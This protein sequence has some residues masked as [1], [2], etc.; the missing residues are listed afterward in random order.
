MPEDRHHDFSWFTSM[1][2]D[3]QVT[4][5]ADPSQPLSAVMNRRLDHSPGLWWSTK[6]RGRRL[7]STDGVARLGALRAQLDH[8]WETYLD[9]ADRAN[10]I[11]LRND[12]LDVSYTEKIKAANETELGD[13]P[14]KMFVVVTDATTGKFRLPPEIR[15]YVE[16]AQQQA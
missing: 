6:G 10:I 11:H 5:L 14:P 4:L 1:P 7:L 9:G 16:M 2:P 13:P 15:A 3:D 12:D 8:W